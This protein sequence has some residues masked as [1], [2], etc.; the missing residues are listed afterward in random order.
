[1]KDLGYPDLP[2]FTKKQIDHL[3]LLIFNLSASVTCRG[4]KKEF[5][6]QTEG[7][8]RTHDQKFRKTQKY[9]GLLFLFTFI[10]SQNVKSGMD[11]T[12]ILPS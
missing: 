7:H 10:V 3:M 8:K 5:S 4:Q 1:M 6:K 11:S 9:P 2:L 12:K